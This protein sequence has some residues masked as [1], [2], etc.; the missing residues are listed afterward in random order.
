MNRGLCK[1]LG[2][3]I[4]VS[5][6]YM[7]ILIYSACDPLKARIISSLVWAVIS[8]DFLVF[9]Q[10]YRELHDQLESRPFLVTMILIL[11]SFLILLPRS[12][13]K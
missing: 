1:I 4:F 3:V 5:A 10:V 7:S 8:V 13:Q 11:N 9:S 2:G 6:L 12:H